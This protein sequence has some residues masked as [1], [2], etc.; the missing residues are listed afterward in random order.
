MVVLFTDGKPSPRQNPCDLYERYLQEKIEIL[1]IAAGEE[2]R[3]AKEE[4]ECLTS[5]DVEVS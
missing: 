1:V 4:L 2:V 3:K 5:P